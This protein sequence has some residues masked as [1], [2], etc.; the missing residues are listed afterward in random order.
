[1]IKKGGINLS[2]SFVSLK[3]GFL[4]VNNYINSLD[5]RNKYPNRSILLIKKSELFFIRS[6]LKSSNYILLPSLFIK[7]KGLFKMNL[8]VCKKLSSVGGKSAVKNKYLK[9]K[10]LYE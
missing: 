4:Y 10:S 8:S 2:N 6:M 7:N 3:D 5:T 1:L 9:I